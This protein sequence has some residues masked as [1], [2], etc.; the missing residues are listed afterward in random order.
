LLGRRVKAVL[1]VGLLG[2]AATPAL[3][4][5]LPAAFTD[6]ATGLAVDPPEPF[7]IY[8]VKS[9]TYDIAVVVNSPTGQ[10]PLGPNDG[11]LCQIGYKVSPANAALSQEEIN[12]AVQKPEW[13]DNV[14][15][16]LSHSFDITG[17]SIFMLDGATGVELVGRPKLALQDSAIFISIV[18]TPAGR[19][20]LNCSTRL[21]DLAKALNAFR[22]IRA[23]I[24]LPED[25]R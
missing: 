15:S 10:P 9:A 14:A 2:L 12:L 25:P 17:K 23:G 4:A 5:D 11:Y 19:T 22:L 24:T 7:V 20:T 21:E 8:P 13:L 6:P 18:D 16:A 3:P 1:L